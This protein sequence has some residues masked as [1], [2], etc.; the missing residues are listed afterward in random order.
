MKNIKLN[1][2]DEANIELIESIGK[3]RVTRESARTHHKKRLSSL[4]KLA[5]AGVLWINIEHDGTV[6]FRL[7]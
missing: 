7:A 2:I 4:N 6:E 3:I 1:S 5:K